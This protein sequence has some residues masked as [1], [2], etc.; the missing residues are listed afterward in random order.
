M[1]Q[2]RERRQLELRI[3]KLVRQFIRAA[4]L[5]IQDRRKWEEEIEKIIMPLDIALQEWASDTASQN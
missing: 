2:Q 5:R 1:M 4:P 3:G